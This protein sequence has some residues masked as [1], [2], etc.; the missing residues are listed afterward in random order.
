MSTDLATLFVKL[1]SETA[2]LLGLD[3]ANMTPSQEA[4]L[5]TTSML[6]F[7]LDRLQAAQLRGEPVDLKVVVSTG[8]MLERALRPPEVNGPSG[9]H[10]AVERFEALLCN[11]I[12]ERERR[13]DE[14][15]IREEATM[16]AE[17]LGAPVKS[18]I[19]E[20]PA[21]AQTQTAAP[22]A[23]LSPTP[24]SSVVRIGEPYLKQNQPREP[25]RDHIAADGSINAPWF[26]P[27]G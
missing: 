17:A 13:I 3:L 7:E 8:E 26:R 18:P 16:A 5:D 9:E 25:W 4:R 20:E 21:P 19:I 11:I 10:G 6:R 23:P 2:R 1:R 12:A 15:M 27:H 22:L 14:A 24:A